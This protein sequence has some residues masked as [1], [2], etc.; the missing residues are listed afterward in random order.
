MA[1]NQP[2]GGRMHDGHYP[3]PG[4]GRPSGRDGPGRGP[5]SSGAALDWVI[6]NRG[7]S[8][9]GPELS[10]QIPKNS[11]GAVIGRAGANLRDLQAEHGVRVYIE[12][13]DFQGKRTVVLSG[14]A[15]MTEMDGGNLEA[16]LQ[17]CRDHIERVVDEQLRQRAMQATTGG[18]QQQTPPNA[19]GSGD[20]ADEE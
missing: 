15:E 6:D 14:N 16:A 11:V 1:M 13:D 9:G 20:V 2:G 3:Q 12:K 5:Q 19:S 4:G 18:P 17:R 7:R 8:S 10:F